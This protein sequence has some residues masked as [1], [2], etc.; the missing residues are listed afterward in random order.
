MNVPFWTDAINKFSVRIPIRDAQRDDVIGV[1]LVSIVRAIIN[2]GQVL[3]GNT[4]RVE[5]KQLKAF[6]IWIFSAS[7]LR[8]F[9]C[10]ERDHRKLR[11]SVQSSE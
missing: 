10:L 2:P 5:R 3:D 4:W 6:E 11:R 7:S 1:C 8:S 9:G